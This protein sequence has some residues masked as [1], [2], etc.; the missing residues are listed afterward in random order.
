MTQATTNDQ[1]AGQKAA[2]RRK[3]LEEALEQNLTV[4]TSVKKLQFKRFDS[5][6]KVTLAT[7]DAQGNLREVLEDVSLSDAVAWAK[8]AVFGCS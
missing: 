1:S 6:S 3:E 7:K 4:L 5:G 2:A 8:G